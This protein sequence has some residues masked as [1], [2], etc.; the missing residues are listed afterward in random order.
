M[1]AAEG[2]SW[3]SGPPFC[4]ARITLDSSMA[5]KDVLW[6]VANDRAIAYT[7]GM[8]FSLPFCEKARRMRDSRYSG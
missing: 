3:G 8:G 7:D 4:T 2:V 1:G 5:S 6:I